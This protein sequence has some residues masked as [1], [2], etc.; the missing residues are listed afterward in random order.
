MVR[1][2]DPLKLAAPAEVYLLEYGDAR[3]WVLEA[4][5]AFSEV[6]ALQKLHRVKVLGQPV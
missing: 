1:L 4:V 6:V 2:P 5:L 3:R